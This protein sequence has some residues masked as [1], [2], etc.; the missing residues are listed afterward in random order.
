MRKES[1]SVYIAK[2]IGIILVVIGHYDPD[3]SPGHWISLINVIYS[4]HMPLFFVLA[5]YLCGLF[6]P[7]LSRYGNFATQKAFRLMY[8]FVSVMS[9]FMLVKFISGFFV[10]LKH[11]VNYHSVYSAFISPMESFLPSLWFIYTLFIIFLLF[12]LL[13]FIARQNSIALCFL[14]LPGYFFNL[15][16]IFCINMVFAGLPMFTFGYIAGKSKRQLDDMNSSI[17]I[18]LSVF[19]IIVY[20]AAHTLQNQVP[21]KMSSFLMAVSGSLVCIMLS[22]IINSLWNGLAISLRLVGF[23]SMTIYLLHPI[24]I[25]PVRIGL[26][27]IL[28]LDNSVFLPGAFV[29]IALGVMCPLLLEKN[30]FRKNSVSKKYILG[31]SARQQPDSLP[32]ASTGQRYAGSGITGKLHRM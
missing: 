29:A 28:K 16:G 15:P 8:P 2:G 26:H 4:F 24:F 12:P 23:Y 6:P 18:L 25:S 31:L 7:E 3:C 20:L 32:I 30:L 22:V 21:E 13:C 19:G 1:G 17:A 10:Q 11:P 27:S 5:G 14:V 9:L